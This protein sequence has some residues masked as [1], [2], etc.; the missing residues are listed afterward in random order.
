VTLSR[1]S[2]S[3]SP[4]AG[5]RLLGALPSLGGRESRLIPAAINTVA[6]PRRRR[7]GQGGMPDITAK[8]QAVASADT[9]LFCFVNAGG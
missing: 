3:P 7:V 4:G 5:T 1:T 8:H 9:R 6:A 2:R